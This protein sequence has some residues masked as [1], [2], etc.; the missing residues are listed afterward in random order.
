MLDRVKEF[1]KEHNLITEQPIICA[2]SGGVDSVCLITI[3]HDLGYKVILAHVN[4]HKRLQ[5]EI[6][7]KQMQEFADKLQCP[8]ELLSYYYDGN[9]NF[10]NDSHHAR[11]NFFRKLCQKYNTHTIATAHHLNDQ[12]ETILIKLMEGSNLYGYGGISVVNDD[13][14][15]RIIRP[16]LCCNKKELYNYAK[17]HNLIY[18]EDSSNFE[19]DFLR[20][21]IRHHIIP[22]LENECSDILEKIS[23]FSYQAKEAFA[24]IRKQSIEY[25]NKTN[26]KI[27]LDDF[28]SFDV[29]L[30]KDI[31][32]LLLERYNMRKNYYLVLDIYKLLLNKSGSKVIS[33]AGGFSL[34]KNYNVAFIAK[35][36]TVNS[37]T[38][39][40][41]LDDNVIY[42]DKYKFY[43][44]KKLP[45]NNAK[46]IKLCYNSLELPFRVRQAMPG[47]CIKLKIGNKKVSRIFIDN[48]V[49]LDQRLLV[50]IIEDS[51][52]DILWIYNLA[53]SESVNNQ[54]GNGDIYFVC[55]EVE[56][57][58]GY[59]KN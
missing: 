52:N 27:D 43:F 31:I 36:T 56:D 54:K 14:N 45:L 13:G 44:S 20:N 49:P 50:P 37:K 11:Y 5:S 58:S 32:S 41:D 46:Y 40:I 17:E 23:Q 38:I 18:F 4:H 55:E 16:L 28:N 57:A 35:K 39:E 22:L 26:N 33:L 3:L 10:H 48:K 24:F 2:V 47:D 9:D 53:K 51:K 21:R 29:A 7:Q 59:N 12:I 6:E 19:D 1:I 34:F 30:K 8:F 42:N 25:L 15:Y